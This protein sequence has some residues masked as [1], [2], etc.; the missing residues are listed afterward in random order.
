MAYTQAQKAATMRDRDARGVQQKLKRSA[1]HFRQHGLYAEADQAQRAHDRLKRERQAPEI[2]PRKLLEDLGG[3][4]DPVVILVRS[5]HLTVGHARTAQLLRDFY[6]LDAAAQK[7]GIVTD[8][9]QGGRLTGLDDWMIKNDHASEAWKR[10][11]RAVVPIFWLPVCIV[12]LGT[13]GVA[14]A[15]RSIG[16]DSKRARKELRVEIE[17]GLGAAASFLEVPV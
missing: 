4:R 5:R 7:Q 14:R 11:K 13:A 17:N 8:R 10:T 12:V 3:D 2:M 6:E 16:R 9:V 1:D 15:C